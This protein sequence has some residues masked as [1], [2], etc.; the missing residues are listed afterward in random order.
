MNSFPIIFCFFGIVVQLLHFQFF[1]SVRA[2]PLKT[3]MLGKLVFRNVSFHV[4]F[5]VFAAASLQPLTVLQSF[6]ALSSELFDG[7][8]LCWVC[9][10]W[11]LFYDIPLLKFTL[12]RWFLGIGF[13]AFSQTDLRILVPRVIWYACCLCFG[14]LGDPGTILGRS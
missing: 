12:A 2:W 11:L 7:L 14:V 13:L 9:V 6:K 4:F 3:S 10:V 8:L 5:L 1:L